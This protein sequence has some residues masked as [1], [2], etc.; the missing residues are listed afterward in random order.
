LC[1]NADEVRGACLVNE[2]VESSRGLSDGH[3]GL[4]LE[5]DTAGLKVELLLECDA[6]VTHQDDA[7]DGDDG[8]DG[9][10]VSDRLWLAA[11]LD[12]VPGVILFE[13]EI[14]VL[15]GVVDAG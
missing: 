9:T 6:A 7:I 13:V 4:R 8:G 1:L 15:D 2:Q 14:E 10:A 5:R 3:L 11:E 12:G